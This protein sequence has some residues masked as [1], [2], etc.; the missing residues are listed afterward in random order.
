MQNAKNRLY[1]FLKELGYLENCVQFYSLESSPNGNFKICAT[2]KFADGR[3]VKGTG[4]GLKKL[5]AEVA[6]CKNVL[7]SIGKRHKELLIDWEQ[8]F[9]EAQAGDALIKLCA[10]L[11]D[12]FET[13][14]QKSL[15]LQRLESDNHLAQVFDSLKQKNDPLV[16][17]FG[18]N[19]GIKKKATWIEALIWKRFGN[20]CLSTDSKERL[21]ELA[22]FLKN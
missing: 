12:S 15:W 13:I 21:N 1:E 19:L 20:A 7:S 10:Y 11:S 14:E 17:I 16:A 5:E 3:Q 8:V 4:K 2:V 22:K 6:A 9:V 18:N